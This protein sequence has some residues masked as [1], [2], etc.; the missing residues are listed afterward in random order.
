VSELL[1]TVHIADVVLG[2]MAIEA[3]ALLIHWRRKRRGIPP[4]AVFINLAAGACLVLALRSVLAGSHWSWTAAWLAAA[5][6]A[7]LV[8]LAHRWQ[9]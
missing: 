5:F 3:I 6:L 8:D 4:A 2:V 1:T 9:R 7:H